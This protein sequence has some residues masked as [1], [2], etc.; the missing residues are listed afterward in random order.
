MLVATWQWVRSSFDILKFS[1]L[2]QFH[3][4]D[5]AWSKGL[6]LIFTWWRVLR[7]SPPPLLSP[8]LMGRCYRGLVEDIKRW[9]ADGGTPVHQNPT[10]W[11]TSTY[12]DFWDISYKQPGPWHSCVHKWERMITVAGYCK[13][14]SSWIGCILRSQIWM[15]L[16]D[17]SSTALVYRLL[18][19]SAAPSKADSGQRWD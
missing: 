7:W 3:N 4:V 9:V 19:T 6:T 15:K 5:S 13:T 10:N 11:I 17:I 2:D 1:V 12:F 16:F 14:R 18:G 8:F